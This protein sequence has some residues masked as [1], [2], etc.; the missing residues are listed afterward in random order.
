MKSW[1]I[2]CNPDDFNHEGA[3]RDLDYVY[4]TQNRMKGI[5]SGDIVYLYVTE[6]IKK[7]LYQCEV[8]LSNVPFS[9]EVLEDKPYWL[10]VE[11]F[12]TNQSQRK[13]LKLKLIGENRTQM[14]DLIDLQNHG[15]TFTFR[16][17][18][19]IEGEYLKYVESVFERY[20]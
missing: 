2:P 5:A 15:E 19:E 11:K 4:W 20:G 18:K 10:D 14:L 17:H 3:F 13:Y 6:P 1:I 8:R 9:D 12:S 7:I 16:G